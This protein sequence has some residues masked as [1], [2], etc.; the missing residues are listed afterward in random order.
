MTNIF[1]QALKRKQ[2][3][4]FHLAHE[5]VEQALDTQDYDQSLR[6]RAS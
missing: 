6:S 4:D 3:Y 2:I 1:D 5:I